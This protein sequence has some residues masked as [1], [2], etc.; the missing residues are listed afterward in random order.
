MLVSRRIA[1]LM[2]SILIAS[3]SLADPYKMRFEGASE[4]TWPQNIV[5]AIQSRL[6]EEGLDPGPIDGLHGPKT[7]EAIRKYQIAQG[8]VPDGR[9]SEELLKSL[10]LLSAEDA[11]VE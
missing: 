9:I 10:G 3:A 8:A 4:E 5:R 6:Q 1:L 7:A 11:K 2:S